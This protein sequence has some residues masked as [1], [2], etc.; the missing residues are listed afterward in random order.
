MYRIL[1]VLSMAAA[2]G[3]GSSAVSQEL[4]VGGMAPGFTLLDQNGVERS[5]SDYRGRQVLIYFY[6]KDFTSGCTTEACSIRDSYHQYQTA[7]IVVLGISGD[8]VESHKAFE[9]E[10]GLPFTLLADVGLA[11]ADRYGSSAMKMYAKR[12]SFLVSADGKLL[13]I[14]RDVNPAAHSDRVLALFAQG[15]IE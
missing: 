5:L 3:C 12:H 4:M 10:H 6:P 15:E 14:L 1:I 9:K 2:M 8:S 13:A 7:G 11:V